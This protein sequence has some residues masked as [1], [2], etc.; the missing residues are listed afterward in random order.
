MEHTPEKERNER[1]L[2]CTRR[3]NPYVVRAINANNNL[4]FP[5]KHIIIIMN[6][7]QERHMLTNMVR[8][9]DV[10][11]DDLIV[12]LYLS[13]YCYPTDLQVRCRGLNLT[14]TSDALLQY[15]C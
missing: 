13:H 15:I 9:F 12:I 8:Y 2:P 7:K 1:L 14:E 10:C 6:N 3:V 5:I 11:N 4:I